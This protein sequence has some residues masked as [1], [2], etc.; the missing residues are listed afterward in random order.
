MPHLYPYTYCSSGEGPW[1]GIRCNQTLYQRIVNQMNETRC[2]V[3]LTHGTTSFAVAVEGPH[4]EGD[5]LLFGPDWLLERLGLDLDRD[6]N[7]V[8]L[9]IIG[10]SLPKGISITLKPVDGASVE[11][12]MFIEGLTEALNQLGVIQKGL[13]SA[14]IDPS[15]PEIHTFYIDMIEPDSVC[16]ADGELRV[17][18]ERALNRPPSPPR[19][20]RPPTP[21]PPQTELLTADEFLQPMISTV[22]ET[23]FRPFAGQGNRLGRSTGLN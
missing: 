3:Y 18:L 8:T 7:E 16:L 2:F 5:T 13:L 4:T 19:T 12:P 10:H 1:W 17:E 23:T 20:P 6:S 14:V 11:G 15:L 9:D 22:V 21:I